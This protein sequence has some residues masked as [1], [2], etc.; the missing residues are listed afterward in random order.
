MIQMSARGQEE[1]PAEKH[2]GSSQQ[3]PRLQNVGNSQPNGRIWFTRSLNSTESTSPSLRSDFGVAHLEVWQIPRTPAVFFV[4][5]NP[6][7]AIELCQVLRSFRIVF[8]KVIRHLR[9]AILNEGPRIFDVG[10]ACEASERCLEL[11][12]KKRS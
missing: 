11:W 10:E 7:L 9:S 6:R 12:T 5:F 3:G 1:H 2:L 8:L 4:G